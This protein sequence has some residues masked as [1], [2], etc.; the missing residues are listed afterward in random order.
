MIDYA[1]VTIGHSTHSIGAFVELLRA[2]KVELVVDVRSS[3]F[4]RR[5][6]QFN[7]EELAASLTSHGIEYAFLGRELG[8]R[9]TDSRCYVD[10][11]VAYRR[12]AETEAFRKGVEWVRKE[13]LARRLALMCAE[14]EPLECHRTLLVARELEAVGALVAH[15][16]ADGRLELHADAVRRL[17]D[18]FGLA[19]NDLF[20]SASE[21]VEEAYSRQE[22]R[23]AYAAGPP[24]EDAP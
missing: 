13:S 19:T 8:G 21:L 1:I 17:L 7:R 20:S 18:L 9:S 10:G 6:P 22:K 4:S 16:H 3:P 24:G 12:V 2:H 14:K 23:V 5:Q 15:I 11:R